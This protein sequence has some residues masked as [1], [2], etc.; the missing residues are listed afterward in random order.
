[1][2]KP[3]VFKFGGT[4]VASPPAIEAVARIVGAETGERVVVVS[5]TAGTTDALVKA[6]EQAT[7]GDAAGAQQTIEKLSEQHRNLI[8]DLIGVN[9]ASALTEIVDLTDRTIAL[10][11]SV[12]LLRECSTRSLDS[13]LSY[14]E[15]VSA[16]IV[17][18]V[19]NAKGIAAEALS[20]E[21]LVVTDDAFGHASPL[22]EITRD[23]IEKQLVPRI[24]YGTVPVVTGFV[25]ST[26]DGVTTTLGR[27]GSDYSAAV[28]AAALGAAECRIYTDVS[29]VMSADPRIV[30]DARPL[31]AISYAEAAELSYFGA[32]VIHPRTV[33]PAVEAGI[34]VRI[35]N[36]FAPEDPGTTITATTPRDHTVVKATTSLG[37]LGLVTVQGAGMSGVPGFAARVFDTTAA[38]KISVLMISQASS[39]NSICLVVPKDSIKRLES[40]LRKMFSQEL[41]RHD[42][43]KVAIEAPVAIVS[44]VGE[45]MRG[46]P[47]VAA[48]LFGALGRAKVNVIA[49]AQGSSELNISL[50]VSEKDREGAVRAIHQEFHES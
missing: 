6:A 27:G 29:G 9:G 37:G 13:I 33:L 14:G 4:S 41:A 48:R 32:K 7:G 5:A 24:R 30:P 34:P 18:A 28:L 3:I 44:A 16:P 26:V 25:G 10:L 20:A 17:A 31:P 40:A 1:M 35:L 23:R 19:L 21:G 49:I 50:V 42:V 11:R 36:T 12:A 22:L 47:G 43:E 46:T 8:A 38:E 15:R 2:S 45:G 39:E